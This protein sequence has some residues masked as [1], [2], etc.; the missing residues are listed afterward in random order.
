MMVSANFANPNPLTSLTNRR[1]LLLCCPE[2]SPADPIGGLSPRPSGSLLFLGCF[3]CTNYDSTGG[4]G[5]TF[6][7]PA[8]LLYVPTV[9]RRICSNFRDKKAEMSGNTLSSGNHLGFPTIPA[10]IG[11]T[12]DEIYSIWF[13]VQRFFMPKICEIMRK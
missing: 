13:K 1:H 10:K 11:E 2:S 9:F 4:G 6:G 12:F 8:C 3:K 7:L 5:V